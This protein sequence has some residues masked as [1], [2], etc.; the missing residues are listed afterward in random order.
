MM[1]DA[2]YSSK[3]CLLESSSITGAREIMTTLQIHL[4]N[5]V[6]RVKSPFDIILPLHS[7]SQLPT[8]NYC[9]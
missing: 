3:L 7:E 4:S 9:D 6:D 2:S 1:Y 8:A 5:C